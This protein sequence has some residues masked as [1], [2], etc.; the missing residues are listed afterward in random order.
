MNIIKLKDVVM[1]SY[2]KF[3]KFFNEKLKGKYAYWIQ[4]R[5][6]FPLDSLDYKTYV[7]YEQFDYVQFLGPCILE[8]IDTHSEDCD[9]CNFMQEYVDRDATNK[10]NDITEFQIANNYVVDG[11]IDINKLRQFRTWLASEI[12]LLNE[13][14]NDTLDINQIH[15][16]DYY[17]NNM[18]NDVVKYLSV[19]GNDNMFSLL[20]TNNTGCACCNNSTIYQLSNVS[21]CNALDIYRKNVHKLMVQLFENAEF[22]AGLNKDFIITFKKYIDNI[23]KTGMIVSLTNNPNIY[24]TC[25]CNDKSKDA[26]TTIL[27]NLSEALNYI[28]NDDIKSHKN[29]IHDSLYNWADQLYDYMSW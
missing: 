1:P 27:R 22:W 3:S 24:I 17:K 19:F 8:H 10:A 18:Y 7:Q 14:V 4:M 15:M 25:N 2:F 12:L 29:F 21:T 16:L 20:T 11:D 26:Y 28:I 5:Y 23:I 9:I 6:I 13:N